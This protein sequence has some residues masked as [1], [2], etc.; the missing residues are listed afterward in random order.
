MGMSTVQHLL[1]GLKLKLDRVQ[2][3][4]IRTSLGLMRTTPTNVLLDLA[5]ESSLEERRIF[6][7]KKYLSKVMSTK[8]HTLN[9]VLSTIDEHLNRRKR[10]SKIYLEDILN[11]LRE[12]LYKTWLSSN[13]QVL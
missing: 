8:H 9:S 3:A 11:S 2:F 7:S 4:S 6:L 5:G 13:L 1:K 10:N 12:H